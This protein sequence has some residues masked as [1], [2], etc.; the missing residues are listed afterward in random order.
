MTTL[1]L[2]FSLL[3]PISPESRGPVVTP[4][5]LVFVD[6]VEDEV[7]RLVVGDHAFNLPLALLPSDVREG[8]W[9]RL[10]PFLTQSPPSNA[11][12]LRQRL[13]ER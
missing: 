4:S 2:L 10:S 5:P 11:E 9:L 7:A 13:G 3:A 1:A 12:S 6:E 8:Q